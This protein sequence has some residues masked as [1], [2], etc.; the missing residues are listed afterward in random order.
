MNRKRKGL[1]TGFAVAALLAVIL[2]I[3]WGNSAL[4]VH[5]IAITDS[6]ISE[7]FSGFRIV[8]VSDLHNAE[9]GDGNQE[10][11]T[12]LKS[13]NPDI[14]VLTGDLVDSSRTDIEVSLAF[15]RQAVRIAPTYYVTGN[16]EARIYD[17]KQ[18]KKGLEAAEILVLGNETV[19]LEK[20]GEYIILAGVDDPSFQRGERIDVSDFGTDEPMDD[21]AIM[22]SVLKD[23]IIE[24]ETYTVLLSHRPELFDTYVESGVDL[25]MTGHAHGGQ[26]RLPVIGGVVAPGQGLFPKYDA[27]LY[28]E[29][30]TNMV[31]SR[32]LGNSV[33]PFRIN[34]RPEIVVVE[35]KADK[36]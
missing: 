15:A 35:L 3:A 21:T 30:S 20:D 22:E 17:Y 23:I 25:V 31:V 36:S 13:T 29:G 12:M 10:L 32:G 24:H 4:M 11:L 8:Q 2:W 27:G 1:I 16:H 19:K 5:E 34:N 6:K 26:F 18:L 33:I 28:T 14:I 9:F 7:P